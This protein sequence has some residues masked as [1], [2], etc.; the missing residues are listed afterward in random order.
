MLVY[1]E[2]ANPVSKQKN[3]CNIK[4]EREGGRRR[5]EI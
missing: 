4:E 1:F 5:I 3:I 2:I